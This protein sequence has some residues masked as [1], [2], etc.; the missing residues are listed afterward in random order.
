LRRLSLRSLNIDIGEFWDNEQPAPKR[1]RFGKLRN[2]KLTD[3]FPAEV[4]Q[5]LSSLDPSVDMRQLIIRN[6]HL[7]AGE[8][9]SLFPDTSLLRH[10]EVL[11][12][13]VDGELAEE[14]LRN[15]LGSFKRPSI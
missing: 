3:F 6:L 14:I 1:L 12:L 7:P 5:V 4:Y 15:H 10:L 13:E 2:L 8:G 9:I 11:E